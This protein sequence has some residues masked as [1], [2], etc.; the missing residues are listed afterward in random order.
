M[1]VGSYQWGGVRADGL[2]Q[3]SMSP[4]GQEELRV[5]GGMRGVVEDVVVTDHMGLS[6]YWAKLYPL[7][8][9]MRGPAADD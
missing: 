4:S 9:E 7:S 5:P 2:E 3:K 1:R 6:L 8:S